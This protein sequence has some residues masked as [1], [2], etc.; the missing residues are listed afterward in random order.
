MNDLHN[1]EFVI[2]RTFDAP[3]EKLWKAWTDPQEV[4]KWWGPEMFTV[5]TVQIDLRVGGKYLFCMR[6]AAG[7]GQP[8]MDYWSSGMYTEIVPL[9]KIVCTDGF[10]DEHGN[11]VDPSEYGM[12]ATFPRESIV[13]ITFEDVAAGKTKLTIHY[14]IESEVVREAM[15]SSQMKEGWESSLNKLAASVQ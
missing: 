5:P 11:R 9:E 14:A 10:A 4:A 7:L 2:T 3:R 13:T 6:G 8:V 15:V 12:P 1:K